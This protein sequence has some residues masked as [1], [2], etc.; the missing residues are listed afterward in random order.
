MTQRNLLR[1]L[2]VLFLLSVCFGPGS[3]LAQ[4]GRQAPRVP[5]ATLADTAKGYRLLSREEYRRMPGA[6]PDSVDCDT[7]AQTFLL[8]RKPSPWR[9]GL[10]AGP[11]FAYCGTWGGTFGPNQRDKT[12]YNGMGV[13]LTGNVD[14]FITSFAKPLRFGL[15]AVLGYQNFWTRRDYRDD[16]V[17]Q[18]T[19][20]GVS[21]ERIVIR[22]RPSEDF[23]LLVGPALSWRLKKNATDAESPFLEAAVRGG[24]YL[25]EA[26]LVGAFIRPDN[27]LVRLVMPTDQLMH[28]GGLVSLGAYF[29]LRNGWHWGVQAQGFLTRVNYFIVNGQQ[30]NL[31]EYRR[32]H[33]GV[34]AGLG[35]RKSFTTNKLVPKAAVICPTCD[36]IPALAVSFNNQPLA[37]KTIAL[38]EAPSSALPVI[39][40][41]SRTVNP[42]NETFTARLHYK[43][44]DADVI[45]SEVVGQ[46]V[47]SLAFPASHVTDGRPM[48]GFYYVTVHNQQQAPCG[49]CMSE[50]AVASFAFSSP[51][52]APPAPCTD[53]YEH[54]LSGGRIIPR[55]QYDVD[56]LCLC[57]TGK[58][59]YQWKRKQVTVAR[60]L[61]T[62]INSVDRTYPADGAAPV[63]P[64]DLVQQLKQLGLNKTVS[65]FS[66]IYEVQ[67]RK[68]CETGPPAPPTRMRV[69]VNRKGQ[70]MSLVPL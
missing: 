33:G 26:A 24:V 68:G 52:P 51:R 48:P 49:S 13:N 4:S 27:R 60:A 9:I 46:P 25:T 67:R 15:G 64:A 5:T 53:T 69:T 19:A 65:H 38:D 59:L 36:S 41:T 37:G 66:F 16:L 28:A 43:S 18:A 14:Y 47:N 62:A 30:D 2:S 8:M 6:L 70:L 55:A 61:I 34:N 35:V 17:A 12:L 45:I 39:T 10:Y 7:A 54:R 57:N 42:K 3:A 1:R 23:F 20:L 22:N 63:L 56:T 40:W 50:I 21:G 32:N 44:E 58:P 31:M 29:P 11:N